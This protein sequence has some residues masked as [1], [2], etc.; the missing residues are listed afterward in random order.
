MWPSIF[1]FLG[2]EDQLA[3]CAEHPFLESCQQKIWP[4]GF[5]ALHNPFVQSLFAFSQDSSAQSDAT[6]QQFSTPWQAWNYAYGPVA[7]WDADVAAGKTPKTRFRPLDVLQE[8]AKALCPQFRADSFSGGQLYWLGELCAK[9]GDAPRTL[10]A[11][12]RY[13]ALKEVRYRPQGRL[14]LAIQQMKIANTWEAAWET[15]RSILQEDPIDS[16][17]EVQ[18]RSAIDDEADKNESIALAWSKERYSL[19][20]DRAKNPKPGTDPVSY[21]WVFTAG[22]DLVHRYYLAG[23][24]EKATALVAEL[25]QLK[26]VHPE[27]ANR[28]G[29]D[30]VYAANMEMKPAPPIPVLKA[31]GRQPGSDLVQKGRI[32]LVHFMFLRCPPCISDLSNLDKFEQRYKKENILIANVTTYQS[33]LQPDHPSHSSVEAALNEARH[34]RSPHL[35]M[36]LSPEQTL[37]DYHVTAFPII[38]VIDKEGRLRFIGQSQGFDEGKDVDRLIRKLLAE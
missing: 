7:E 37:A 23:Q 36:A 32:E 19:L 11:E 27:E 6:T 28:W 5:P 31:M 30:S 33:A 13:L 17:T 8:R 18:I 10:A 21:V 15:F 2:R 25:N 14:T 34:K 3:F 29:T 22:G 1:P 4:M 12:K 20:L 9:A 26:S 38:A 16:S 35:M 24:T